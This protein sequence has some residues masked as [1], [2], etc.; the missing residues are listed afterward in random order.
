MRGDVFI[1]QLSCLYVHTGIYKKYAAGA[2]ALQMVFF[3]VGPI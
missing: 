1:Y 2:L 3:L